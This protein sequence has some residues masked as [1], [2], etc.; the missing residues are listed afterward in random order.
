MN[1]KERMIAGLP[2]MPWKDGLLELSHEC[3][4]KLHEYNTLPPERWNERPALLASLL[5][6]GGE[7]AVIEPPFHCDY[8]FNIHAGRHFYANFNLTILDPGKVII[9]DYVMCA[10]NVAIYTAGHPLHPVSRN[11][12]YEYGKEVRIGNNVWLGGNVVINPGI[13]I[14][15]NT[16]IGSGSV[17][18]RNMP[19]NV[20]AA[21]NPCKI[22]REIT[23][24][25]RDY[26]FKDQRFDVN[27]YH[28]P[29][30]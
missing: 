1:H 27:D 30:W 20:L 15:D 7:E 16:V 24:K 4:K 23:E 10:P 3:R 17:V 21:G 22:I 25:D 9:G 26:Y 29:C 19:A 6:S 8:G 12:G 18:T 2:Y 28:T 5:G 11:S 14:G 13:S